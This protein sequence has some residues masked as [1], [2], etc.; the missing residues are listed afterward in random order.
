MNPSARGS[1]PSGSSTPPRSGSPSRAEKRKS[2][3]GHPSTM[4]PSRSKSGRLDLPEGSGSDLDE[5][6]RR[7]GGSRGGSRA[8]SGAEGEGEG[9]DTR[10]PSIRS[11]KNK[12]KK[13]K[14][15][16]GPLEVRV[17]EP[18]DLETLKF[19]DLLRILT[20]LDA[21]GEAEEVE[22]MRREV[23]ALRDQGKLEAEVRNFD[24]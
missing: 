14:K 19:K 22:D 12:N 21:L 11:G 17:V 16:K 1:S 5:Q 8:G 7:A 4:S 23:Q 10:R 2:G 20:E 9:E 3:G 24:F 15:E 6:R 18:V 13:D